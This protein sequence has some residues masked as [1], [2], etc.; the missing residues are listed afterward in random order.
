M[1]IRESG[2]LSKVQRLCLR[3]LEINGFKDE[4]IFKLEYKVCY[5]VRIAFFVFVEG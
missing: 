4:L 2:G 5:F 1:N 3:G